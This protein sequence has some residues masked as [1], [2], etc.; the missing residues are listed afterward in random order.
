MNFGW[1]SSRWLESHRSLMMTKSGEGHEVCIVRTLSLVSTVGPATE[2]GHDCLSKEQT[3]V[4]QATIKT[5][6]IQQKLLAGRGV[7]DLVMVE[8]DLA[9]GI[10]LMGV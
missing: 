8:S 7:E 4:K 2:R 10:Q 9:M 6:P 3:L 1:S 5:T